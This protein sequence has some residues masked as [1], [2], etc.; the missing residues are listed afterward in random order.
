M[1]KTHVIGRRHDRGQQATAEGMAVA[2]GN[3]GTA[4]MG[5]Q[6]V[7]RQCHGQWWQ[8]VFRRQRVT[9]MAS[10]RATGGPKGST[11]KTHITGRVS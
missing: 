7:R 4:C 5:E 1:A 8:R 11:V 6:R 2:D 3:T 10:G 9:A